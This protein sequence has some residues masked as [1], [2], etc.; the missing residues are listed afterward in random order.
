M[1]IQVKMT[2]VRKESQNYGLAGPYKGPMD[3]Y[4]QA[5]IADVFENPDPA[6][7]P[8]WVRDPKNDVWAGRVVASS[9]MRVLFHDP[10]DHEL[11]QVGGDY[12]VTFE[13]SP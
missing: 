7:L 6:Y 3:V 5:V 2:C 9:N 12:V 4:F 1:S 11:I 10:A 8:D 13:A